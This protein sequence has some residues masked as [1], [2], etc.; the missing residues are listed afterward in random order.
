[1]I[2]TMLQLQVWSGAFYHVSEWT[3]L[4]G[5]RFWRASGHCGMPF[6]KAVQPSG[7]GCDHKDSALIEAQSLQFLANLGYQCRWFHWYWL[8]SALKFGKIDILTHILVQPLTRETCAEFDPQSARES[9]WKSIEFHCLFSQKR[10]AA[11]WKPRPSSRRIYQ[12][13]SCS[14]WSM[15]PMPRRKAV[16]SLFS[17]THQLCS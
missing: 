14:S 7:S 9:W 1:M 16:P 3:I 12:P 17:E 5:L 13:C 2:R 15:E 10:H 8:F 11:A 4:N 6:F